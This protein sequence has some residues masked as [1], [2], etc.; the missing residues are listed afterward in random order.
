MRNLIYIL[1][2]S[3][4][5]LFCNS[6]ISFAATVTDLQIFNAA[7]QAY[8]KKDFKLASQLYED[9]IKSGNESKELYYN[10]GNSYF[11]LNAIGS[12]IVNFEKAKRL[13]PEDDDIDFNLKVAYAKVIDKIEAI[14][15]PFYVDW[16]NTLK[17]SFNSNSFGIMTIIF[18][19]LLAL[20]AAAFLLSCTILFKKIYFGS[21]FISLVMA[22]FFLSIATGNFQIETSKDSAIIISKSVYIKSAPEERSTDAFILHE[23]TKIKILD[24]VGEWK[25]FKVANGNQGWIMDKDIEVI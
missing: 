13:A 12:A 17:G 6:V 15:Q 23:G 10:L 3:V 21:G 8:T 7:N 14:P 25:K 11:K 19:W 24:T 16:Y 9:I 4:F 2:L 1:F 20:S 18:S 5:S 22:I